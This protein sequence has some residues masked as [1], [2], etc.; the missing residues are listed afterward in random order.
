MNYSEESNS[1]LSSKNIND[2]QCFDEN[3]HHQMTEL[4]SVNNNENNNNNA[5]I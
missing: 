5:N 1:I 3:V 2:R 4:S